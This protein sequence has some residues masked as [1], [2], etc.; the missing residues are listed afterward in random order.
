MEYDPEKTVCRNVYVS[1]RQ[2]DKTLFPNP[3]RFDIDL[4]AT[5]KYVHGVNIRNYKYFPE[6]LVN[7]NNQTFSVNEDGTST[8]TVTIAKGDYGL[9][10]TT[11][12]TA[13][14]NAFTTALGSTFTFSVVSG[15]QTVRIALGGGGTVV[16]YVLIPYNSLLGLL[17]F[18]TGICLYRTG[19]APVPIPAGYTGYDTNATATINYTLASDTDL[20]VRI[21]DLEAVLAPDSAANRATAVLLSTRATKGV[22]NTCVD[23]YYELLQVQARLQKLRVSLVNTLGQ[24]YDLDGSDASFVIEFHCYKERSCVSF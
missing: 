24:N 7:A 18:T 21:T 17:G 10:I 22:V 11:L 5:I 15:T 2:R 9:D 13:L 12:L 8:V 3:Y 23:T 20:I 6:L 1:S 4:P 19:S 14:G 16:N